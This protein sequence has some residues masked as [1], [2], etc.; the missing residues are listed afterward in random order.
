MRLVLVVEIRLVLVAEMR[1]VLVA[2]MRLVGN[3]IDTK[4]VLLVIKEANSINTYI[5]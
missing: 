1:L 2:G 3:G 4:Q 5:E